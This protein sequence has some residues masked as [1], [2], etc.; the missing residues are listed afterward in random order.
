MA[1]RFRSARMWLSLAS[2][3]TIIA[4]GCLSS[5]PN[6][7]QDLDAAIR[8]PGLCSIPCD[9]GVAE[10]PWLEYEPSVAINPKDPKNI[11]VGVH[12]DRFGAAP[13]AV[14]VP[15]LNFPAAL[16][17]GLFLL[18]ALVTKDAGQTWTRVYLPHFTN[19]PSPTSDWN[20]FCNQGDPVVLFGPDGTAYYVGLGISCSDS[21]LTAAYSH[22]FLTKSKDGGLTWGEPAI[23]WG[24]PGPVQFQ[25]KQW[26]ALDPATGHLAISWS[27]FTGCALAVGVCTH[28]ALYASI[29][30]DGGATWTQP[31][32]TITRAAPVGG[33]EPVPETSINYFSVPAWG[34]D[35]SL[36]VAYRAAAGKRIKVASSP[37][38]GKTWAIREAAIIEPAK[39]EK[40]QRVFYA[41]P[42]LDADQSGGPHQGRLY[43]SYMSAPTGDYDMF[44]VWSDDNGASW[45]APK[46]LNDNAL[47]DGTDQFHH[48]MDVDETGI[49]HTMF[50]DRRNDPRNTNIQTAYAR[51]D[52]RQ[53]V[54]TNTLLEPAWTPDPND[55]GAA[56]YGHYEGIAASHGVVFVAWTKGLEAK[57]GQEAFT[58]SAN[59][60]MDIRGALP[61]LD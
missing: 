24:T 48:W 6:S 60:D 38:E 31:P 61:I 21:T 18:S 25:D 14:I 17:P 32:L 7:L 5:V 57:P 56:L 43:L 46:R 35:G 40:A 44:L 1:S 20:R 10:G 50:F 8:L 51:Y 29:S 41:Y 49:V 34:N 23:V 36:H 53:D 3:L 30:K 13:G 54:L 47:K 16:T 9:L 52:P 58:K 55:K 33:I 39:R 4:S 42:V 15:V 28:I 19:A 37:D 26:A 11:I 59:V 2:A 27:A 12:D 45:S 22:L